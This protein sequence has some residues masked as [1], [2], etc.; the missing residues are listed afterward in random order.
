M[1]TG[2]KRRRGGRAADM[3]VL[4]FC[5]CFLS[6]WWTR[7]CRRILLA[8]NCI[9]LFF[10]FDTLCVIV[11]S[12]W[13]TEKRSLF[14]V[15]KIWRSSLISNVWYAVW[16]TSFAWICFLRSRAP[17]EFLGFFCRRRRRCREGGFLFSKFD[18]DRSW[19]FLS[20]QF[21]KDTGLQILL[22]EILSFWRRKIWY[23]GKNSNS[24]VTRIFLA[25]RE[26]E[27]ERESFGR[28][29]FFSW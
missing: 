21:R 11:I 8:Q 29:P 23:E 4:C 6:L 28:N 22:G 25:H 10:S 27:R 18:S 19:F 14:Y 9:F 26:R 7:R 16:L 24:S 17:F 3:R 5:R 2:R 13:P 1:T 20:T 15:W 12:Q